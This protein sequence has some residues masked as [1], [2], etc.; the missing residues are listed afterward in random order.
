MKFDKRYSNGLSM[1][2]AYTHQKNIGSANTGSIIGNT[3]T[4]TTIGRAV[5][6]SSLVAGGLSGGS[7]GAGGASA[8]DPDNRNQDVA[9]TADDIPNVLNIAAT[10]E[11]PIG[12]GKPF[13][14]GGGFIGKLLGGWSLTQNWNF[15]NGVPLVIRAP[16]DGI[17]GEIGICRP[18]LVGDP[19][20]FTGSRSKTDREN[21]WFNPNAFEA[22][23]QTNPAIATAADPT[24]Y[25][26]WWQFGN[27]GVHNG[28]VRSPGFWNVDMSLAKDF[29]ITEQRYFSFRWDVY[30]A[31][32]HQNLGIPNTDW[33]LGPNP[34]GS[35]DLV[36]QFGC[37]FGKIT[38]IQ[39]DPR[40]MQFA[41][42]FYF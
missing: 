37:Q 5:G 18:N 27:M 34:D 22:A 1:A 36:H 28:A 35:T 31:L 38:N 6:R 39:T 24:I 40:A 33:C 30:N 25:D 9:L 12:K 7:G 16:C 11:L 8:Q 3:A 17:Q 14:S 19:N 41:V 32:N 26:E 23:F 10:Y 21:Q 15:Q 29:H 13:L 42:K 4:P 20:K 2:V